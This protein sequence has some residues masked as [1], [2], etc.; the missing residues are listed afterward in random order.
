M[1]WAA[2]TSLLLE[3]RMIGAFESIRLVLCW[4]RRCSLNTNNR[5]QREVVYTIYVNRRWSKTATGSAYSHCVLPLSEH[6]QN[7]TRY[8][9]ESG[10]TISPLHTEIQWW[11]EKARIGKSFEEQMANSPYIKR[12]LD[13]HDHIGGETPIWDFCPPQPRGSASEKLL[14]QNLDESS[15]A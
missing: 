6:F 12:S 11:T 9:G 7:P 14:R 2:C 15:T 4:R 8:F 13:A 10:P 5:P 3:P 1:C